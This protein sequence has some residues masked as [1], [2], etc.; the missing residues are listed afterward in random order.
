MRSSA[1]RCGRETARKGGLAPRA[2]GR[3]VLAGEPRRIAVLLEVGLERAPH[4]PCLRVLEPPARLVHGIGRVPERPGEL[5]HRAVVLGE[6]GVDVLVRGDGPFVA[7]LF[8]ERIE[9]VEHADPARVSEI[10]PLL[11]DPEVEKGESPPGGELACPVEQHRLPV[12][13]A[14]LG[15]GGPLRAGRPTMCTWFAIFA[16]FSPQVVRRGGRETEVEGAGGNDLAVKRGSRGEDVQ[17][18]DLVVV[19]SDFGEA[20]DVAKDLAEVVAGEVGV[21]HLDRPRRDAPAH[22]LQ[23]RADHRH[24]G[25]GVGAP[26]VRHREDRAVVGRAHVL[27]AV[28]DEGGGAVDDVLR[29]DR[30]A[31]VVPAAL[32]GDVAGGAGHG[33]GPRRNRAPFYVIGTVAASTRRGGEAS[34]RFTLARRKASLPPGEGFGVRGRRAS[35][36]RQGNSSSPDGVKW[37]WAAGA[38]GSDFDPAPELLH[39]VLLDLPDPLRRHAVLVGELLEGRL[40]FLEPPPGQDRPAAIVERLQGFV[41]RGGSSSLPTPRPPP[42][43]R[44]RTGDPRST[45]RGRPHRRR[46]RPADRRRCRG[47]EAA[48]PSRAR[49]ATARRDPPRPLPP[50]GG[51]SSRGASWRCAG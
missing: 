16:G 51:S 6:V 25:A 24:R 17:V 37:P 31:G 19:R 38:G 1:G 40:L 12:A 7:E 35:T 21:D 9:G 44:A 42:A 4:H 13:A 30:R 11:V 39:G 34:G 41:E 23:H 27:D 28:E 15:I 48:A 43:A 20:E 2:Q 33:R 26:H 22:R 3:D 5:L 46:R 18:V 47:R 8:P 36:H 45:R 50:P 49:C 10:A 29:A 14:L 32:H